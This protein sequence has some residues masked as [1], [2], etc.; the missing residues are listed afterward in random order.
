MVLHPESP[1]TRPEIITLK[2]IRYVAAR[3]YVRL[4]SRREPVNRLVQM[5]R[6]QP[7]YEGCA[8]GRSL[9]LL[10]SGYRDCA[11]AFKS[12]LQAHRAAGR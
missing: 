2:A 7:I 8:F 12:A 1:G 11:R 6:V 9:A 10:V 4:R 5:Y 3:G